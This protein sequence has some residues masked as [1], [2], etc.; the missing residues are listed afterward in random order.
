MS[1]LLTNQF[2]ILVQMLCFIKNGS[3]K[4][5][6]SRMITLQ[7]TSDVKMMVLLVFIAT[8]T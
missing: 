2:V 8:A 4:S 3:V 5:A 7:I 1:T 6:N